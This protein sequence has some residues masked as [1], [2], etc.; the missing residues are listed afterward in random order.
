M[1]CASEMRPSNWANQTH[2]IHSKSSGQPELTVIRTRETLLIWK[3]LVMQYE[4][5]S[6]NSLEW[7]CRLYRTCITGSL[8]Y[9]VHRIEFSDAWLCNKKRD[10]SGEIHTTFDNKD[11][12]FRE[13]RSSESLYSMES[14]RLSLWLALLEIV[15]VVNKP[16]RQPEK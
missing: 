6:M 10:S 16:R 7:S 5:H 1:R 4:L 9:E 14:N 3:R 13:K 8:L 12:A 15:D 2:A 11:A